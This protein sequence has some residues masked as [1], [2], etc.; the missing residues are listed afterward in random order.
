MGPK[1]VEFRLPP[2]L[3][4]N[5][6]LAMA[7]LLPTLRGDLETLW[8]GGLA[9]VLLFLGSCWLPLEGEPYEWAQYLL[10]GTVFPALLVACS[11]LGRSPKM[12]RGVDGLRLLLAASGVVLAGRFLC[13]QVCGPV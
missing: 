9:M 6:P 8:V 3:V 12:R 10:L 5:C 11:L 4:T 2:L 7:K 13:R 1:A